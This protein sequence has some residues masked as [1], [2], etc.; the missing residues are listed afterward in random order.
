MRLSRVF[1]VFGRRTVV[2]LGVAGMLMMASAAQ[3]Q[4]PPPAQPPAQ[5]AA[6]AAPD[7]LK[8]ENAEL[9]IL[10]WQ[11][12]PEKADDFTALIKELKA[13]MAMSEKPEVKAQGE[14]IKL[15]RVQTDPAVAGPAIFLLML[16]PV[17]NLTY[18]SVKM[19][20]EHAGFTR[21]EADALYKRLSEAH[22][23][24]APWNVKRVG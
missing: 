2:A 11:I 24:L 8:F 4:E 12:K 14:S 21:E 9:V 19:I 20:Y 7:P 23:Q 16:E 6:P 17:S 1:P 22:L 13:K 18:D 3:A 5:A 10:L 15:N